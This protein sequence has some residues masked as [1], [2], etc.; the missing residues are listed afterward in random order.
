M[1]QIGTGRGEE[2]K[3][4]VT[5]KRKFILVVILYFTNIKTVLDILP[6]V[7]PPQVMSGRIFGNA[8]QQ[9]KILFIKP[10]HIN[11]QFTALTIRS[12]GENWDQIWIKQMYLSISVHQRMS[13]FSFIRTGKCWSL[14][15]LTELDLVVMVRTL[16]N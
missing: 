6:T 13:S 16:L 9:N 15:C 1:K 12:G 14:P 10:C 8:F 7:L 11:V 4:K 5:L 3:F 2:L